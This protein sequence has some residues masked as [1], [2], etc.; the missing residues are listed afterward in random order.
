MD[1][2]HT[3]GNALRYMLMK[4]YVWIAWHRYKNHTKLQRFYCIVLR[5]KGYEGV[6]Q[7]NGI[8]RL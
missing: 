5:P 2:D 8:L 7:T 1:E 4:E 3:I 6:L